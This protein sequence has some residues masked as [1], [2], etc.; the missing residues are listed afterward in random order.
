DHYLYCLD[1]PTQAGVDTPWITTRANRISYVLP[2]NDVSPPGSPTQPVSYH[3]FVLEAVDNLGAHSAPVVDAFTSFTLAPSVTILEPNATHNDF[4]WPTLPPS[5]AF[6]FTGADPDGQA[7]RFPV[8]YKYKVFASSGTEIDF[9][10][11]LLDTDLLRRRYAPGFAGWDSVSGDT[12]RVAIRS[13]VPGTEYLFAVTAIDEA[14]A[15]SPVFTLGTSLFRFACG[16]A[17]A[18][19]PKISIWD[20]YFSYRYM[21]GGYNPDPT[22]AIEIEVPSGRP[23]DFRWSAEPLP[24][25]TVKGYRWALDI[26]SLVD[27]TPRADESAD[28]QHWSRAGLG[29]TSAAVGPF[30]GTGYDSLEQHT[31]YVEAEDTNLLKSLAMVR[32]RV[33]RPAFAKDLLFVNDTRFPPDHST[34]LHPDSMIA[35]TGNWPGAAELDTFLYARGG[36]RWRSTVPSTVKSTPGIFSGY[37]FDTIGSRRYGGQ[38]GLPLFVLGNYRHIVWM[39][40]PATQFN[41]GPGYVQWPMPVLRYWSMG[42]SNPLAVYSHMGGRLW[43]LGGGIAYNTLKKYNDPSNDPGGDEFTY[44]AAAGELVAG[45]LMWDLPHWRSEIRVKKPAGAG[46]NNQLKASW[47]GAPNYSLLPRGLDPHT[48]PLPPMR[49]P[50]QF[51]ATTY[52]GEVLTRTNDIDEDFSDRPDTVVT[53]SALDTLYW[54]TGGDVTY[55]CPVMTYYHGTETGS[56]VFCGF[57]LWYFQRAQAMQLGDFVLQK[58]WGLAREPLPR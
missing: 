31:L 25:S 49:G 8:K 41:D 38:G 32:F 9:H 6:V 58:I 5:A 46:I 1:P 40:D 28:W 15:Y 54:A 27:E 34:L 20:E 7:T 21:S 47:P 17:G 37:S 13:M 2:C 10:A 35:P 43:L 51:Y 18:V 11:I 57:P 12:C 16:Y 19:G 44:S 53:R 56:V 39:C 36:V 29:T 30:A 42:T 26:A 48:D 24:G 33:T 45:R 50:N 22:T 23:I 3:V 14:G 55:H 52:W 4:I